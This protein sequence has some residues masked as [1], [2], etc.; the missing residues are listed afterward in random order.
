[1]ASTNTNACDV[2]SHI[3]NPSILQLETNTNV[4]SRLYNIGKQQDTMDKTRIKNLLL[5]RTHH[6]INVVYKVVKFHNENKI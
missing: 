3:S 4:F 5:S 1:M 2:R 6:C